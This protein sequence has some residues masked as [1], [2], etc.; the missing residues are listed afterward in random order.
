MV[1]H[2][3]KHRLKKTSSDYSSWANSQTL[4][5]GCV[6]ITMKLVV[7]ERPVLDLRAT[8]NS[9]YRIWPQL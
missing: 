1:P 9:D 7:W 2:R 4:E 6:K 3:R 8:D 5:N